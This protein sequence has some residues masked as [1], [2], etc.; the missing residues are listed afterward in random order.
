MACHTD[1]KDIDSQ[2]HFWH[3]I[4]TKKTLTHSAISGMSYRQNWHWLTVPSLAYHT[5][6]TDRQ[7][8]TVPFL[9]CHTDKKDKDSHCHFKHIMQTKQTETHSAILGISCRQNRQRLTVP[10]LA[11]HTDKTDIDSQ[12]HFWHV[13]QTKQ[14]QTHS[15]ISGMS[16]RQNSD[17]QCHFWHVIQ[18]KQW[19]TVPFLAWLTVPFLA[20]HT[21]KTD[22]DSQCHFWQVDVISG[23]STIIRQTTQAERE[24]SD[25][26]Q[27]EQLYTFYKCLLDV[28]APSALKKKKTKTHLILL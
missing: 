6:K 7:R 28:T 13:M 24:T 22:S 27:K 14:T 2:C 16:Y 15:A 1:K 19:L 12:C 23:L 20:R 8:L 25:N 11:C 4:Q 17:S 5:D 9:A 21:G 26:K 18:T 10:F 3:V